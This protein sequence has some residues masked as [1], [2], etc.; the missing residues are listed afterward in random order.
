[1]S[2]AAGVWPG[3]RYAQRGEYAPAEQ[4][5]RERLQTGGRFARSDTISVIVRDLR[6]TEGSGTAV[7]PGLAERPTEALRSKSPAPEEKLSP[8]HWARL[9]LELRK[10]PLAHGFGGDQRRTLDRI[11]TLTGRLFHVGYT[12]EG[13]WKLM[14]R[15]RLVLSGPGAPG[16]RT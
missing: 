16:A 14:H 5:R 15:H 8:Q 13:T 6:V 3:M 7:V 2:L 9:E 1:M 11:K 12:M 10:G 4:Q